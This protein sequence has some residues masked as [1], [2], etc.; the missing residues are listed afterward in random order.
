MAIGMKHGSTCSN[1][2]LVY[3]FCPFAKKVWNYIIT[4]VKDI[5]LFPQ[6]SLSIVGKSCL[7]HINDKIDDKN[8]KNN[9]WFNRW[10][11]VEMPR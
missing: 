6:G 10:K 11:D 8:K 9:I 1:F 2:P 4:Y 3:N 7:T 5:C